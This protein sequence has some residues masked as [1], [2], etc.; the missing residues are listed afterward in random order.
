[1]SDVAIS[2]ITSAADV[3]LA[4]QYNPDGFLDV[5]DI[6]AGAPMAEIA[7]GIADVQDALLGEGT[8]EAIPPFL[9]ALAHGIEVRLAA[10]AAEAAT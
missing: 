8:E 10:I 7:R 1:M 9:R 2:I 6:M 5:L 4:L 3:A